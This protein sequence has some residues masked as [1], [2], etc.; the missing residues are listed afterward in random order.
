MI[1]TMMMMLMTVIM[2]MTVMRM[3]MTVMMMTVM[4]VTVVMMMM[5]T[6]M[7]VEMMMMMCA[8]STTRCTWRCTALWSSQ[9][10]WSSQTTAALWWTS[11][12]C[13][14][15]STPHAPSPSRTS[16][17]GLWRCVCV[18]GGG[19]GGGVLLLGTLW[20]M[21]TLKCWKYGRSVM[22]LTPQVLNALSTAWLPAQST[23]G[24]REGT[25]FGRHLEHTLKSWYFQWQSFHIAF[26]TPQV[27]MRI[28]PLQCH[29]L[30]CGYCLGNA[31]S[32]D[33]GIALA[34]PQVVMWVFI[35]LATPQVV[36]RVL[37]SQHHKLWCRYCLCNATGCDAGI[38]YT[39]TLFDAG[40]CLDEKVA[41]PAVNI[42]HPEHGWSVPDAECLESP[43]PW[44]HAHHDHL[45][46]AQP[47][48]HSKYGFTL[49]SLHCKTLS[50]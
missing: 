18:W 33:A 14:L 8:A 44:G 27:V 24:R 45:L 11:V 23:V 22:K 35:A 7:M 28:L 34:T 9:S 25:W 3:L 4:M 40:S 16:L 1:I 5:M 41:V 50:W 12:M 6:V 19:G 48:A 21:E 46:H 37:P 36:M 17:K 39:C 2:I 30:W 43:L 10:W 20:I 42:L 38:M 26:A 47:R 32:C 15:G 31:T 49:L 13:P 29:K